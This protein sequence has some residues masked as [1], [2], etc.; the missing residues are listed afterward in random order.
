M[1]LFVLLNWY[2]KKGRFRIT[3]LIKN[4]L[5]G[6]YS[7]RVGQPDALPEVSEQVSSQSAPGSSWTD[8]VGDFTVFE[9]DE[10]C[11]GH[12]ADSERGAFFCGFQDH[13][14]AAVGDELDVQAK[15]EVFWVT[16]LERHAFWGVCGGR[17]G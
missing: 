2:V 13:R 11:A 15:D 14:H 10:L 3:Y 6:F 1:Q 16:Q 9:D 8:T 5:C 17:W 12:I 4:N 7:L